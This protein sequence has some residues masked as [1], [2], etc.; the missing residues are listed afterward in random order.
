MKTWGFPGQRV[1]DFTLYCGLL[2]T[3]FLLFKSYNVTKNTNDL[4]LC[5]QIVKACDAASL[6]SRF[7]L[8]SLPLHRFF[9][10]SLRWLYVKVHTLSDYMD[11]RDVTFIC[12]RA[13]VC[14]LGA[15]VAKHGSDDESF[16]YYL[17]QFQKV[18]LFKISSIH[19]IYH[20]C[21]S[22]YGLKCNAEL[23]KL[24]IYISNKK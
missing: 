3:A 4:T 6:R 17:A 18:L 22:V 5:S 2:G 7:S 21:G 20:C 1:E 8:I 16:S 9:C 24:L 13:G 10:V 14:A 11:C 19:L 15:V 12:G 23:G